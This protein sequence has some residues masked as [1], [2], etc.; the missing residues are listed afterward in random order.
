[1]ERKISDVMKEAGFESRAK[2]G[3]IW[4]SPRLDKETLTFAQRA[5]VALS[6]VVG[7]TLTAEQ[8]KEDREVYSRRSRSMLTLHAG[9]VI[10]QQMLLGTDVDDVVID[11]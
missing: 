10:R 7:K 5:A 4:I 3:S 1:M 9:T 6:P 2:D 8:H 11:L